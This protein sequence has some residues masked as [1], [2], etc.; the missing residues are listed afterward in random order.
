M[1]AEQN[2]SVLEMW[3]TLHRTDD[4]LEKD[5]WLSEG[6]KKASPWVMRTAFRFITWGLLSGFLVLLNL[7]QE[8]NSHK[9]WPH[10]MC[11]FCFGKGQSLSGVARSAPLRLPRASLRVVHGKAGERAEDGAA[12]RGCFSPASFFPGRVRRD[13]V[14]T[15]SRWATTRWQCVVRAGWLSGL[16]PGGVRPEASVGSGPFQSRWNS[17]M[18]ILAPACVANC[19]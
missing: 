10:G 12:L 16:F 17:L 9:K 19:L 7:L 2:K 13:S 3:L 11:T 4:G 1:Y 14:C 8:Q 5:L 15:W 6:V 18:M